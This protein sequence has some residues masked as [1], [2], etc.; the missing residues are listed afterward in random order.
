VRT[1]DSGA[2]LVV[3]GELLRAKIR[4]A[5]GALRPAI[6]AFWDHPRLPEMFPDFLVAIYGSVRATI[7][8]MEAASSTSLR[9]DDPVAA[10]LPGYFQKHAQEE[11]NHD[12]WL[13]RDLEVMGFARDDETSRLPHPVISEMVGAQYYWIFHSHPVALLGFFAVLEGNPPQNEDLSAVQART[14]LPS[15]A[16]RMLR[17]HAEIDDRHA[18]AVRIH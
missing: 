2:G 4:L 1:A 18:R 7:P 16:F 6:D 9:L 3:N 5:A 15:E 12:E 13:L 8:L 11:I 10:S 14:G 17:D